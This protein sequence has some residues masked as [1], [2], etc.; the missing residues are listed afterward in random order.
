M[1]PQPRAAADG[2]SPRGRVTSHHAFG[3]NLRLRYVVDLAAIATCSA[4]FLG[5]VPNVTARPLC[6]GRRRCGASASWSMN[7]AARIADP[8]DVDEMLSAFAFGDVQVTRTTLSGEDL[9]VSEGGVER[10]AGSCVRAT[11]AR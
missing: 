1:A 7:S 6:G 5:R 2:T 10:G 9:A 3:V 11:S 8:G 4:G